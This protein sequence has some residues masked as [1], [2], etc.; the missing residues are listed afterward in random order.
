MVQ[1][2][3]FRPV[4]IILTYKIYETKVTP[5]IIHSI[6]MINDNSHIQ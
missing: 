5:L 6:S 4:P 3:I 1:L 2:K